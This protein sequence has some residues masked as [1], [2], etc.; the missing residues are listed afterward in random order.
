[1]VFVTDREFAANL[2]FDDA[3]KPGGPVAHSII[4]KTDAHF[5]FLFRKLYWPEMV[6]LG[7][8]QPKVQCFYTLGK[9]N[10][11]WKEKLGRVAVNAPAGLVFE[12]DRAEEKEDYFGSVLVDVEQLAKG[13]VSYTS[14]RVPMPGMGGELKPSARVMPF[15]DFRF[16]VLQIAA[17]EYYHLIQIWRVGGDA[18]SRSYSRTFFKLRKA[19]LEKMQSSGKGSASVQENMASARAHA[20]HPDEKAAETISTQRLLQRRGSVDKGLF[21]K[22][23]PMEMLRE[24][25][26]KASVQR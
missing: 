10:W 13:I 19:A 18:H 9:D 1:M 23:L 7:L 16:K 8:W 11:L 17:H 21:D 12:G 14:L 6:T 5:G 4:M 26:A 2:A 20:T 15:N 3:T 25:Y 24:V 22:A